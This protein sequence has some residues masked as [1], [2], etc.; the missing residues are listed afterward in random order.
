MIITTERLVGA[1][2]SLRHLKSVYYLIYIALC[3]IFSLLHYI[4]ISSSYSQLVALSTL[5]LSSLRSVVEW[6]GMRVTSTTP[7]T[8]A[9]NS[10]MI[11]ATG[12][13]DEPVDERETLETIIES[14]G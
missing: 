13:P 12:V 7:T 4:K 3:L 11:S 14:S 5:N 6:R 10:T 1:V 9:T 2:N 8:V